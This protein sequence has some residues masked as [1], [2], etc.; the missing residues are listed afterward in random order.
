MYNKKRKISL[1]YTSKYARSFKK[2]R[3]LHLMITIYI[4]IFIIL[5]IKPV[6]L[7]D[8]WFENIITA[9]VVLLLAGLYKKSRLTNSSYACILVLL[10]LHAIGA[11]YS[12]S[13]CPIGNWLKSLF[14]F[15]RNNYDRLVSF[16]FG[17]FITL[18]VIEILYHRLRLRYIQACILSSTVILSICALYEMVQIYSSEILS[19]QQAVLFLGA[20]G[21]VW[22]TQNDM[23]ICLVGSLITMFCCILHK[24]NKN[25][26]IH[27][28]KKVTN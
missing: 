1:V 19:S 22:D 15:K 6:N 17:L 3:A 9:I 23:T 28:V 8:W 26:K 10:I 7:F 11:H 2:D 4:V 5:S 16:A 18:P 12:Y 20:Q 13:F 25:H 21:E 27:M 14:G 24:L